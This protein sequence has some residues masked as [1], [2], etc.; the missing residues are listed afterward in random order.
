MPA[1]PWYR[2]GLCF[3]CTQCGVCCTGAPGYVWV[4]RAE[5]DALAE[6]LG[7]GAE[8]FSRKYVRK[9]GRRASLTERPGGDC[10]FWDKGCTVYAARPRQCRT[11]PFWPDVVRTR[12]AWEEEA[13][14]CRGI[15][16]GRLYSSDEIARIRRGD[17]DGT[18]GEEE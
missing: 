7:I 9:V 16:T 15:G 2:D 12:T 8:A 13:E 14:E 18:A 10:V 3:S 6:L 11:Y 17:V 5:I 1:D 4:T